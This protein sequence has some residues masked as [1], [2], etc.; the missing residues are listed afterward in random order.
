MQ[1]LGF[2]SKFRS[3]FGGVDF[4]G[5]G[6]RSRAAT[7]AHRCV[8]PPRN[9]GS[10]DSVSDRIRPNHPPVLKAT[11]AQFAAAGRWEEKRPDSRGIIAARCEGRGR[12]TTSRRQSERS[13]CLAPQQTFSPPQVHGPT[14]L[15][16]NG[17]NAADVIE[18]QLAGW[19]AGESE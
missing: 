9:V 10:P 15:A 12:R 4:A 16:T 14:N 13:A 17:T 2:H 5:P 8:S 19:D 3:P 6:H 18:M 1:A 11:P 7:K